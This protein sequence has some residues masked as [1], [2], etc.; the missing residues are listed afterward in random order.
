[1]HLQ[2]FSSPS[3]GLG[4]GSSSVTLCSAAPPSLEFQPLRRCWARVSLLPH[5][6][7]TSALSLLSLA[8]VN[9]SRQFVGVAEML[10]PVDFNKDMKFW[11]LY[12]Y[13]GFFPIRWHIIKDV[14]NAQFCHIHIIVENENRDVTYTRDT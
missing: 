4:S 2:A 3:R 9:A 1:M 6:C 10:G 13:N 8:K 11:K 5:H 12:K 14:P 7:C